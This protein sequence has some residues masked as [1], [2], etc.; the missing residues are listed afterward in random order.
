MGDLRT[1]LLKIRETYGVLTPRIVAEAAK[2]K[3]H[4]LHDRIYDVPQKEAAERYYVGNAA[5]LLRVTFRADVGGRPADLRQFWVVRGDA[6]RPESS[7][8]PIE[9]VIQDPISRE[10]MLR[11]MLRDWKRFK[12]RYSVYTEFTQLVLNDPD[13]IDPDE[14][15]GD[16]NGTEG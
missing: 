10:V 13:F 8:V 6:D 1:E 11:Q 9:E 16:S 12:A 2:P 7:Y 5:K 15:F 14:D 4:P 3:S